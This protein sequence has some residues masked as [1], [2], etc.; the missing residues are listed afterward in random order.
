MSF[1][2]R[3]VESNGAHL[4]DY[5]PLE[6]DGWRAGALRV[7]ISERLL[8]F[9]SVFA[10][11]ASGAV[12]LSE[13]LGNADCETRTTAVN[14]VMGGLHEEGIVRGWR[15]EL[16]PVAPRFGASPSL[17]VERAAVPILGTRGYGV[18]VNG[19]V[20]RGSGLFMWVGYRAADKPTWPGRMD[21]LVAGGQPA[22][23]TVRE[24]LIKECK[25]EAGMSSVLA[26]RA[27]AAGTIAYRMGTEEGYRPDTVFV[28]DLE[29]PESFEPRNTDG[30]VD[31]F[32]C[33]PIDEVK[34]IV[35][36]STAF[37]PNCALVIID[38]LVRHG[39]IHPGCPDY[40]AIVEGL[41]A[42][43]DT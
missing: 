15:N 39:H 13:G 8:D 42:G 41:H 17:L 6:M 27:R 10:N 35:R 3:V 9:P 28:F 34:N 16:F 26:S 2:D 5:V 32:A 37:K 11:T 19:I 40:E 24:N 23:Y 30:E 33:L 36:D 25:E 38:F 21:Q 20:R 31:R 12:T 1:L 29:L 43:I 14:E 7:D 18:H 22:G 4:V